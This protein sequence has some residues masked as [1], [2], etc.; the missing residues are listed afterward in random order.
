MHRSWAGALLP[1]GD[2]PWRSAATTAALG[3]GNQMI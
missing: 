1:R 2:L 3:L